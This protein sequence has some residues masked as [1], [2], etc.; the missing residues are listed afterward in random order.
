M[1]DSRNVTAVCDD[2]VSITDAEAA[3][4]R[5]TAANFVA[6][7]GLGPADLA[8]LL[9]A[10]G[11]GPGQELDETIASLPSTSPRASGTPTFRAAHL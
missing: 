2:P 3:A 11:I 7:Q 8:E 6:R 9:N 10:L 4:A 5:M 1:R